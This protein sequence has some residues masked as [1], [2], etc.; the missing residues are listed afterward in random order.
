MS[1]DLTHRGP[2]DTTRINVHESWELTYWTKRLRCTPSELRE[3][4]NAVG[5]SRTAVE[6]YL[7]QKRPRR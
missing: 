3:A 1:D 7:D 6:R 5:V 2:P 4:V